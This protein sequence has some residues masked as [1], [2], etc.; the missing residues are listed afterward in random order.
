VIEDNLVDAHLAAR[1]LSDAAGYRF[2]PE[3]T[4]CPLAG[5]ELLGRERHAI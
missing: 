2:V 3:P 4:G 5:L 1:T